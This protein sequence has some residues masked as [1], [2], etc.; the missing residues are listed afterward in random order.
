MAQKVIENRKVQFFFPP[1]H[2]AGLTTF[3]SGVSEENQ[4]Q[5]ET[6]ANQGAVSSNKLLLLENGCSPLFFPFCRALYHTVLTLPPV[7]TI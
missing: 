6:T 5:N 1:C 7:E 2:V 3:S 4:S